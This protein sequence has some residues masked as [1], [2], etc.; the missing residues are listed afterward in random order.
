MIDPIFHYGYPIY[1]GLSATQNDMLN[2]LEDQ[3]MYVIGP[4]TVQLRVV[5][6]NHRNPFVAI[7]VSKSLHLLVHLTQ[8]S[9]AG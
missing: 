5:N 2:S 7:D 3:A 6:V 8:T 1:A 9:V 4:S